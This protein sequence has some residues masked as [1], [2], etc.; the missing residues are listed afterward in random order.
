MKK[1]KPLND[2]DEKFI[3]WMSR[4]YGKLP[5]GQDFRL[6]DEHMH[7]VW[8]AAWRSAY[9]TAIVRG[10]QQGRQ[11][12]EMFNSAARMPMS[13]STMEELFEG[14]KN[15]REFGL[16]IERWHGIIP[17]ERDREVDAWHVKRFG[18]KI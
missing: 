16:K 6:S 15:G 1:P 7:E 13:Y 5:E 3:S 2:C 12:I 8:C 4:A 11:Q 10:Q 9:S 17:N 18:H 14:C